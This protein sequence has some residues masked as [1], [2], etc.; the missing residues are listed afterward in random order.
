MYISLFC[1]FF[2]SLAPGGFEWNFIQV[3]L[4]LILVIDG[5]ASLVKLPSNRCHWILT[6]VN[7]GLGTGLVPLD[8]KPL[9]EPML[10]QIYVA[11]WCH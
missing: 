11:I 3:I 4:K 7:I 2:N 6:M 10:N 8:Y 1:R 5:S 9:S